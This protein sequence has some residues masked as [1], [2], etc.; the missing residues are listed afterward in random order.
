MLPISINFNPFILLSEQ[1][2]PFSPHIH[3]S[4]SVQ[5][6]VPESL[7]IQYDIWNTLE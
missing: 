1:N 3:I 4:L 2:I 5:L 6:G 7:I